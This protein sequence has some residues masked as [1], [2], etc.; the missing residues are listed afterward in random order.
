MIPFRGFESHP[1][2]VHHRIRSR[3]PLGGVFL[4]VAL[5]VLGLVGFVISEATGIG[6]WLI[7]GI[8]IAVLG[9]LGLAAMII[10][11]WRAS[12]T[13][14]TTDTGFTATA[15]GGRVSTRWEEI[16][17][18]TATD[19]ELRVRRSSGQ[20]LVLRLP[21]G[22]DPAAVAALADD[23]VAKLNQRRGPIT[24]QAEQG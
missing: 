8:I 13:L 14:V 24:P 15:P 16:S 20:A 21:S 6:G 5:I 2:R 19:D 17:A 22:A 7:A 23:M 18:V 10:G 9:V 4:T 3:L 1:R 12:L 11:W